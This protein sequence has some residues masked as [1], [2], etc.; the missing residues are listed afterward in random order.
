MIIITRN[1]VITIIICLLLLQFNDD[2]LL[3]SV[4][5]CIILNKACRLASITSGN[6][7]SIKDIGSPISSIPS[8]IKKK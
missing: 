7:A 2:F 5:V 6:T 1:T 8:F 4:C 3:I